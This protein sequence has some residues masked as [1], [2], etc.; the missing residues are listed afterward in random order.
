MPFAAHVSPCHAAA[1][2]V[3]RAVFCGLYLGVYKRALLLTSLP[4]QFPSSLR[5]YTFSLVAP[6]YLTSTPSLALLLNYRMLRR[7]K[8]MPPP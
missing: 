6:R 3:L 8:E 7:G 2:S 1:W 4:L 5:A